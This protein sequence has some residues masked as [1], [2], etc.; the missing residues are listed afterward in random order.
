M[1]RRDLD[2]LRNESNNFRSALLTLAERAVSEVG[3]RGEPAAGRLMVLERAVYR[4]WLAIDGL[5]SELLPREP[6]PEV[7]PA[8]G[9]KP[10]A[11]PAA[12]CRH[13][14]ETNAGGKQMCALC[15]KEKSPNGRK[16]A[17]E[18]P[19]AEERTAPLPGVIGDAA[20]DRFAGGGLGSS[21][22]VRR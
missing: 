20:A 3:E 19:S 13:K 21:G 2:E 14:W 10:A 12:R 15:G 16:P 17:A 4:H 9:R 18:R 7:K 6:E 22:V 1:D 8:K 11:E 5:I